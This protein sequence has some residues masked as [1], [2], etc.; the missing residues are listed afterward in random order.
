MVPTIQDWLIK[1][2]FACRPLGML[3]GSWEA[4]GRL[5]PEQLHFLTGSPGA[6]TF[7]Y[8]SLYSK[9]DFSP[10]KP[11]GPPGASGGVSRSSYI[12]LLKFVFKM[13]CFSLGLLGPSGGWPGGRTL[14]CKN[15]NKKYVRVAE[16]DTAFL[17][18]G[19]CGRNLPVLADKM[20]FL[21]RLRDCKLHPKHLEAHISGNHRECLTIDDQRK[22]PVRRRMLHTTF[23]RVDIQAD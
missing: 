22:V 15:M 4:P 21:I 3:G 14:Y 23:I 6:A 1:M 13:R 7:L 9:C 16:H 12:S 17:K 5:L 18:H 20:R 19:M 11:G 2:T 8:L 10:G